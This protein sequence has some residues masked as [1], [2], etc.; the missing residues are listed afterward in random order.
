MAK[1]LGGDPQE[2]SKEVWRELEFSDLMVV[3]L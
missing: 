1:N 2:L 3:E